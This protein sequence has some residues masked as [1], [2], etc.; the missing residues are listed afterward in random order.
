VNILGRV[1]FTAKAEPAKAGPTSRRRAIGS[2]SRSISDA[3]KRPPASE[4]SSGNVDQPVSVG[5]DPLDI[6]SLQVAIPSNDPENLS[7]HCREAS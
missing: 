4:R 7:H 3:G 1:L 6:L 2:C 5:D